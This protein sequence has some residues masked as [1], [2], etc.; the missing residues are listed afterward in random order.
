[1]EIRESIKNYIQ[2][3][4]VN[5]KQYSNLSDSDQLIETGI[6][7]SLGIMKLI[8]FLEDNLSVQID[9][10]ELVPENFST[11]DSITSLVENKLA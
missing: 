9:D 5:D 6:I 7:D 4:L 8:G 10:T 11:I 3:E 1:M 2:T